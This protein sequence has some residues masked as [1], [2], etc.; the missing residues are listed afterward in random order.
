MEMAYDPKQVN[1]IE[2][3]QFH[4]GSSFEAGS[5]LWLKGRCSSTNRTRKW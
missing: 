4:T 5:C 2:I 3:V 1:S